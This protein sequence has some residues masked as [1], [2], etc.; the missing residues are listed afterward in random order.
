MKRNNQLSKIIHKL[1]QNNRFVAI[2]SLSVA[3]IVW[4]VI[5][6]SENPQRTITVTG[7]PLTIDVQGT[8]VE[9]LGMEVVSKDHPETVNVV[10]SGP[11]Y[12]VSSLK[13]S[14]MS[15]SASLAKVTKSGRFTL[16][17]NA[18]R[19]SS[20]T[21]YEIL[22]VSPGTVD[23]TFDFVDTKT[24]TIIP[25]ALGVSAS[26]GLVAE[27]PTFVDA[28]KSSITISGSREVLS[29]ISR[30]EAVARANETLSETTIFDA[31][32][33]FYDVDGAA[34][35]V[36]ILD[37]PFDTVEI[38]VPIF[39]EK[40]LSVK[41]GDNNLS[42][43]FKNIP[44]TFSSNKVLVRG[45]PHEIDELES[46]TIADIDISQIPKESIGKSAY[47]YTPEFLLPSTVKVV[48]AEEFKVILNLSTYTT[49]D[50]SV[51]TVIYKGLGDGLKASVSGTNNITVCVLW[52][53]AYK[54]KPE[55]FETVIDCTN[56]EKGIHT[57]YFSVD[58]AKYPNLWILGKAETTLEIK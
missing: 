30:V 6:I 49:K 42:T 4:L 39:K 1:F 35:D 25:S 41:F 5:S 52:N 29:K 8:L 24:F 47:A 20:K 50:I 36:S 54:V 19:N 40:L 18:N 7:V 11:S 56:K 57:A 3:L 10:V 16:E 12:I 22:S 58:A 9:T 37:V 26:E 27:K 15:V 55:T 28:S 33:K 38:T 43:A 21:G 44:K 51:K 13:G 23:V 17:L 53:D 48:G 46:V 45:E 32:L 14:D 34:V 31:T 2:F